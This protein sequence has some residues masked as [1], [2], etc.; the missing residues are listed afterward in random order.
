MLYQDRAL[1]QSPACPDSGSQANT[2][3]KY[4]DIEILHALSDAKITVHCYLATTEDNA[5]ATSS[6][7]ANDRV[8][9]EISRLANLVSD[10]FRSGR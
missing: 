4:I 2:I 1:F 6:R 8:I 9:H 3:V 5:L 7:T 10:P